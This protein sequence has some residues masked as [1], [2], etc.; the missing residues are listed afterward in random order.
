M[1]TTNP[2]DVSDDGYEEAKFSDLNIGE[3]F[4]LNKERSD[5]NHAYRK[6]SETEAFNVKL[7]TTTVVNR[8]YAVFYKM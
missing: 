2:G 6:V 7:R 3:L 4:W 1:E 8:H 5:D